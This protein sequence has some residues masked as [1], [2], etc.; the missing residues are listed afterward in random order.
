MNQQYPDASNK[1]KLPN[2]HGGWYYGYTYT[3]D[4]L[5]LEFGISNKFQ[6]DKLKYTINNVDSVWMMKY[7]E[8]TIHGGWAFMAGENVRI[9]MLIDVNYF[10]LRM[11]N[12]AADEFK[13]AAFPKYYQASPQGIGMTYYYDYS[14]PIVGETVY[15]HARPYISWN[16]SM[17]FPYRS[18]NH[19]T[20]Y[21]NLAD[22]GISIQISLGGY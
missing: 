16:Y 17:E 5:V 8:N 13:D 6:K 2:T 21:Y 18:Q 11:V 10:A 15:I 14:F 1:M 3:T 22:V 19:L 7:R 4:N 12:V 9:G 20:Y